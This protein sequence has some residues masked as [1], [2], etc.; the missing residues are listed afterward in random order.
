MDAGILSLLIGLTMS[1][2][3]LAMYPYYTQ[4]AA[5]MDILAQTLM[6]AIAGGVVGLVNGKVRS[7]P[8]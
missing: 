3:Y 4:N 6:G 5:I 8:A 7:T 2:W 1:I